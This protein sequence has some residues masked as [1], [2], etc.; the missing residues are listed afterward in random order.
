MPCVVVIDGMGGG[1]G[2]QLVE[3]I[4]KEFGGQVEIIALGINSSATERMM[5]AGAD[6]AAT[7]ENA[8][9]VSIHLG[10]YI[11]GPIGIIIP[12]A[13]MG[14]VT[15]AIAQ[16]VFDA[17][18]CKLLIPIVQAHFILVGVEP[19]PLGTLITEAVQALKNLLDETQKTISASL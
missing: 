18:G 7:G 12:N 11:L 16:A 4:R 3:R 9:R 6:R 19:K 5:R 15:T 13:L 2:A 10:D 14:E 1:I 8:I 17:R